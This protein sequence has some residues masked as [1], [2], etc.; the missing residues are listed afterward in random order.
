MKKEECNGCIY[1]KAECLLGLNNQDNGERRVCA[2]YDD[3][4]EKVCEHCGSI[5]DIVDSKYYECKNCRNIE[6][7]EHVSDDEVF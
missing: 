6:P 1:N 5:M 4:F 7:M 3:D 2:G